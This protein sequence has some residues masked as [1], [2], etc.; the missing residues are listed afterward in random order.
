MST[1]HLIELLKATPHTFDGIP[2]Y[3]GQTVYVV[4]DDRDFFGPDE[5]IEMKV[6]SLTLGTN[7][8]AYTGGFTVTSESYEFGNLDCYSTKESCLKSTSGWG[9]DVDNTE[10][11]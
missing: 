3:L 2:I 8:L 6:E 4:N 5:A 10:F 11:S 7:F 9:R 1:D